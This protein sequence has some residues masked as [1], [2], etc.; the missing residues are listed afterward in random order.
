MAFPF[1]TISS[2]VNSL[3]T[4]S[5]YSEKDLSTFNIS[6]STEMFFAESSQDI[7]EFATYDILGNLNNWKTLSKNDTYS[8][9]N[10]TYK[11]VDGKSFT[12]NYKKFN[13]SYIISSERQILLNTVQD[14][15]DSGILS[16]SYVVSYN[17]L[18]NVAGNNNYK[19]LHISY[20]KASLT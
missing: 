2:N 9:T 19:F 4:G 12:Y 15:N 16:G 13:S 1:I 6:Q 7:I 14:L 20:S 18:R 17:F 11:D 3:N 5:Y 8:V 10:K